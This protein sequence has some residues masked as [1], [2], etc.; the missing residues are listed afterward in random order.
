MTK[1]TSLPLLIFLPVRNGANYIAQ[2]IGSM[3]AQGDPNW[4]LVV[5]ENASSDETLAIVDGFGDPRITVHAATSPL[6]IEANWSRCRDF[7]A[8]GVNGGTLVTLIGHDDFLHPTFVAEIKRLQAIAPDA[9]IYQTL[10]NLVDGD[11]ALIRPCRAVPQHEEWLDMLGA[12][13]WGHCDAYGTGYAF[14]ARDYLAVGGIPALPGLLYADHLLFMSL[15]RLGFKQ[16][17]TA[18]ACSYRLH[19]GSATNRRS[20]AKL[21]EQVEAFARFI[22]AVVAAFPE[23]IETDL[24]RIALA[25]WLDRELVSFE[26]AVVR[27]LLS[28]GNQA[29]LLTL[30]ARYRALAVD[31]GSWPRGFDRRLP[32][33]ARSLRLQAAYAPALLRRR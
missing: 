21:N 14:R 32:R 27:R 17:S 8:D 15:A 26:G 13:G 19:G 31:L 33:L 6:S 24:G 12:I 2:A 28:T 16:C 7:L 1:S 18:I 4:R 23:A 11:G 9:T 5:L 22:D 10:F 30:R 20:T 25:V 29:L 3:V